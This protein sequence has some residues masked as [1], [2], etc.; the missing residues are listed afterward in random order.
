M[1]LCLLPVSDV[2]HLC[3]L[4]MAFLFRLI[5]LLIPDRMV[6]FGKIPEYTVAEMNRTIYSFSKILSIHF[7]QIPKTGR[8]KKTTFLWYCPEML[9]L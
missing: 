9:A 7:V 8:K 5:E 6:A 2:I 3:P 4:L 1:V